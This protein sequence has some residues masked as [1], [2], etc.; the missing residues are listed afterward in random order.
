MYRVPPLIFIKHSVIIILK[1][2]IEIN[3]NLYK[4]FRF[5]FFYVFTFSLLFAVDD[6]KKMQK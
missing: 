5:P 6:R 2:D 1:H 3:K 4:I